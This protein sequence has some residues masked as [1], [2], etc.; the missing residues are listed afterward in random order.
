[1]YSQLIFNRLPRMHN[2]GWRISLTNGARKTGYL[3]AGEQN[4]TPIL[5]HSQ[6]PTMYELEL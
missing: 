1:M 2:E 4:L 3:H 6:K 5:H